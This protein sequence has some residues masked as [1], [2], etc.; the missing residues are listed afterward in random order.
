MGRRFLE[1]GAGAGDLRPARRG[2]GGGRGQAR[3]ARPAARSRPQ[4]CDV[5]DAEAVEAMVERDLG[6]RAARRAGQQRR[7]Q[8]HRPHRG[9]VARA[10]STP[11]STSCST[12]APT[13]TLG[14]RPALARRRAQGH[15]AQH[16]HHLRLDRLGLR[17]AL[18]DGQ[19]RRAGDDAQRWRSSG[20][21]AASASTPS[22][23]ARS[24]PRAPGSGW[25]RGPTCRSASRPAIRWAA[26]A[27]IS[28]L[29]ESRRLPAIGR[30]RL[31]QRR[32]RHDRRRRVAA[33]G[34]PVQ[35][36]ARA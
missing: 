14:L 23:R 9:A 19:G 15:R 34:R 24:P 7:R 18:G 36:P 20:A 17:R 27:S 25:C 1:L 13:C 16:R 28:E 32:G 2:A 4:V 31:H 8:L 35:L 33:G 6:G 21:A 10:P 5:R 3:A 12:A 22:R 30:R 11:C 26:S 29:A